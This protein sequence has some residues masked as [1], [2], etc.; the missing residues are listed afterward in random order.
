MSDTR[1]LSTALSSPANFTVSEV[2]HDL[3][4]AATPAAPAGSAPLGPLVAFTGNWTG[5][6]FNTIFRPNSTKTPTAGFPVQPV[7]PSDNVLELNLTSENLS[8]SPNLAAVPNRGSGAQA[9]IF[10]NGVPYLQSINDVTTL[11]AQGIHL[12]PGIW[13]CVPATTTPAEGVTVARMASIPHGTTINAQGTFSSASGAPTINPVDITPFN[14]VNGV[15]VPAGTFPSQTALNQNSF[16]I[17]QNLAPYMAAGTITQAMLTDPN[18]VLRQQIAHQTITE[19]ATIQI[20]TAPA[21]PL[22]GGGPANIAFLL[23]LNPPPPS[24]LG[25]NAQTVMKATFWIETVTYQVK[26]LPMNA[27]DAPLVLP[28]VQTNPPVPLVPSFLVSIPFVEGK[29]FPGGTIA[30]S[31]TQIQ[32][33]QEVVLNFNGLSWPHVSVATLVPADPVSVPAYLLPLT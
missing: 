29:K 30:L 21:A 8:F 1:I 2:T 3:T 9:D 5:Q 17:P 28:P 10:L 33:S 26:V 13:L 6:G 14:P 22:F 12:E 18:T 24:G 15:K 27:G 4:V 25:P 32:Y 23:G 31:T 7:G 19:T 20:S 16:R 11:P